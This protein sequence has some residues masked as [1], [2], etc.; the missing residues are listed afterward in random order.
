[1]GTKEIKLKII[2]VNVSAKAVILSPKTGKE[3]KKGLPKMKIIF[4]A[5]C[6]NIFKTGD[7][8]ADKNGNLF[9]AINENT[10]V[11]NDIPLKY[12]EIPEYLILCHRFNEFGQE[13]RVLGI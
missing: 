6:E 9:R 4:Q 2:S 13:C 5:I 12:F 7:R 11:N 8:Y 3:V 1:M 10:I